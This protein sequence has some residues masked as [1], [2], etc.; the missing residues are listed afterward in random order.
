[1]ATFCILFGTLAKAFLGEKN[2]NKRF[3]RV[4]MTPLGGYKCLWFDV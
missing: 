2:N 1:M 4:N 3:N